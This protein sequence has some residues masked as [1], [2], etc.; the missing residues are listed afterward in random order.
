MLNKRF[1][2]TKAKVAFELPQEQL[3]EGI[4]V[5][6]VSVLGDFN[7]WNAEATPLKLLKSGKWK[8]TIDLDLDKK[9]AFRYFVNDNVWYND[10]QADEYLQGDHGSTNCIVST[11]QN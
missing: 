8:V 4:E 6:K 11:F 3:P 7:E 1:F 2:K 9:Y 10:P 5:E